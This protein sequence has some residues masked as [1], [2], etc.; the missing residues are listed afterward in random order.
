MGN[1]FCPITDN[2]DFREML[3]AFNGDE[4]Y[5]YYL[6]RENKGNPLYLDHKGEP[7]VL[8]DELLGYTD[9]DRSAALRLKS[10]FYNY[11]FRD[12][13]GDWLSHD[14]SPAE[15]DVYENGEPLMDNILDMTMMEDKKPGH[16]DPR[17]QTEIDKYNK[18]GVDGDAL[19]TDLNNPYGWDIEK[20]LGLI[21]RWETIE[22]EVLKRKHLKGFSWNKAM[23]LIRRVE[24]MGGFAVPVDVFTEGK[25]LTGVKVG[26]KIGRPVKK[27][28]DK[29]VTGSNVEIAG[30]EF[31]VNARDSRK[32]SSTLYQMT[33][34]TNI[35]AMTWL[36]R[37][38]GSYSNVFNS[39][40]LL[41]ETANLFLN[42]RKKGN[43]I[44]VVVKEKQDDHLATQNYYMTYDG[45]TNTINLY[46]DSILEDPTQAGFVA[47]FLHEIN[48][49]LLSDALDNQ[50]TDAEK[51]FARNMSRIFDYV[52]SHKTLSKTVNQYGLRNI[53]EF[54]S[55]FMT[56][57]KFAA[58]LKKHIIPDSTKTFYQKIVDAIVHFFYRLT[59]HR[60]RE[61][62]GENLHDYVKG[63]VTDFIN[64]RTSYYSSKNYKEGQAYKAHKAAI[65][66]NYKSVQSIVN[67]D[68]PD[69][70]V[71]ALNGLKGLFKIVATEE[72]HTY[73]EKE[74]GTPYNSVTKLMADSG[75]GISESRLAKLANLKRSSKIGT[76]TH[77]GLEAA[78][79]DIAMTPTEIDILK[80]A[81][82]VLSEDSVGMLKNILDDI[83]KSTTPRGGKITVLS[84]V[85][86][87]DPDKNLAGTIDLVIIDDSGRIHIFDFKTKEKGFKWYNTSKFGPTDME[88]YHL[89]L[90]I[91]KHMLE[92]FLNVPIFSMNV[93]M[94]K[95]TV[96]DDL[97]GSI[98]LDKSF[99][100]TG[101]DTFSKEEPSV[102]KV[103]GEAAKMFK[104]SSAQ[105]KLVEEANYKDS[106]EYKLLDADSRKVSDLDKIY[107]DTIKILNDKLDVIR[108]RYAYS[109]TRSFEEFV[110]EVTQE[111]TSSA[112]LL[113]I[114]KYAQ[115]VSDQ[116]LRKHDGMKRRGETFTP[117]M[118]M[119]WR[120]Y[121][122]S[123]D[124]LDQ[125]GVLLREDK[126]LLGNPIALEILYGTKQEDGTYKGGLIPNKLAIKDIFEKQGKVAI[127]RLLSPFYNGIKIRRKEE[128]E[129]KYRIAKYRYEKGKGDRTLKSGVYNADETLSKKEID[130][131][132]QGVSMKDF[133]ES[134]LEKE[135]AALEQITYET[136]LKELSIAAQDV[137]EITRWV[138]NLQDTADPIAAAVVTAWT[139]QDEKSRVQ[140]IE[141]RIEIVKALRKVEQFK[142]KT[143][144]TSEKNMWSGL[145]EKDES[146][147]LTNHLL[148]PWVSKLDEEEK[149][150]RKANKTKTDEKAIEDTKAWLTTNFP[151]ENHMDEYLYAFEQYL[152]S[153][154]QQKLITAVEKESLYDNEDI[155]HRP[156]SALLEDGEIGDDAADYAMT[157]KGRNRKLYSDIHE[158][159]V[160][161][162]WLAFMKE[163]GVDTT[164][165]FAAQLEDVRKSDNPMAQFYT[166]ITGMLEEADSMLPYNY[167]LGY[168]LPGIPKT[169]NERIREG[170][171]IKTA[172][173]ENLALNFTRKQEDTTY[174]TAQF[175]DEKGNPKY[176]LPIHYTAPLTV[177]EQ[178]YDLPTIYFKFWEA[179]NDYHNKREVLPELEMAKYFVETRKTE[180]R[181]SFGRRVVSV[182]RGNR[183][184]TESDVAIKNTSNLAAML[185]DWFEVYVYGNTVVKSETK[186]SDKTIIDNQ[187]LVDGLNSFTSLNLLALNVVQG[188]ANLAIG[189]VMTQIDAIAGEYIG[190][191]SLA[192]ASARYARW[193]PGMLG[194]VGARAPKHVGSLILEAFNALNED[195]TSG[196]NFANITKLKALM[197][198]SSLGFA[199][200]AGEHWL[201]ARLIYAFLYEKRAFDKDGN[202]IGPMIE[203]Y[204]AENGVLKLKDNVD[205]NKSEWTEDDVFRFTRKFQ[206]IAT[207]LHGAYGLHERVAAQRFMLGKLAYLFRKFVMP[208]VTRR[209]GKMEYI[210]RL[211]QSTEGNYVTTWK[212]F[213]NL[214][215]DT[216]GFKLALMGENWAALSDH[217]KANIKRTMAELT[218]LV[219][220]IILANFAYRNWSDEDDPAER[221]FWA[222]LA[223][224]TY[225]L[226]AELL[227]WSPKLDETVSLLR[228]P[229]AS[230]SQLENLIRLMKNMFSPTEVY[231]RGPWKGHLKIERNL[232][233]F[234]PVYKQYYKIRDVEEQIQWFR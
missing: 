87:S 175:T 88:K 124:T 119:E 78:A 170:Q 100:K 90:G 3:E 7:S 13:F 228:S 55:V 67:K 47:G 17:I 84:E 194:D 197:T 6:Y 184:R 226:K 39:N 231:E 114:I 106:I 109:K 176:F 62:K 8:F 95:P 131:F 111:Q 21:E 193:L 148:R 210:E 206:G 150:I 117:A 99:S 200:F 9:G 233:Q 92:K 28:S 85:F 63:T 56:D 38:T 212:F 164:K 138:V 156:I 104:W 42:N 172:I 160:N 139:K 74:T 120:D 86:I 24:S 132:N 145:L 177:D 75:Y 66:N 10:T 83:K 153:L 11:S 76:L 179:S 81:G 141:K 215:K 140:A 65:T 12:E 107:E 152:E 188:I 103:Y 101:I 43:N 229:L 20:E 16:M 165:T 207:R 205:L 22:G 59:N 185:T 129:K 157:W 57:S 108:R 112:A 189:E 64:S 126:N 155:K 91:Y 125:L 168:R 208:G 49:A 72:E 82:F 169:K 230:M 216:Q 1:L 211:Q 60:I 115:E 89:Q 127:A 48:H 134:N 218:Y 162:Q 44:K 34:D 98:S 29:V 54:L 234:I 143:S 102:R 18:K 181:D 144:F 225:R 201:R 142:G 93:V 27:A 133:V 122:T 35:D 222:L 41:K 173:K 191:K 190:K 187:K 196:A 137:N 4:N 118:L 195:V 116:L 96:A 2:D 224:Q 186:I 32:I 113:A 167:R 192:K 130:M 46:L 223:Y 33:K 123:Y 204:Y 14:Y 80:E 146:G 97:V 213:S 151:L 219:S 37:M 68:D 183:P 70:F 171:N 61:E 202:D 79:K 58:D 214:L 199:Q 128:L 159:W 94:L 26:Y 30:Q 40:P 53:D 110:T 174:Q 161:P 50:T 135:K 52:K 158:K 149:A 51:Q 221:R 23:A 180:L 178:S 198:R 220:I 203:Q 77:R 154:V 121:I 31:I 45:P 71:K 147:V 5:I 136:L 19:I 227:F 25:T 69:S 163:I 15:H 232:V 182:I 36:S 209:Y 217:E 166:L 105:A 73:T